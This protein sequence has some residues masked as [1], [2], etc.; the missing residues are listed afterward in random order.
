MDANVT[1]LRIVEFQKNG[2]EPMGIT[3]KL[4]EWGR[5]VVSRVL[6]GGLIDRQ[7]TLHVG[8]IITEINCIPISNQSVESLQKLLRDSR[9]NMFSF[10]IVPNSRNRAP[11]SQCESYFRAQFDYNPKEDDMIPSEEAGL[12]FNTGDILQVICKDDYYWWQSRKEGDKG[13]AGLIP[14]PELVEWRTTHDLKNKNNK[15]SEANC[16]FFSKSKRKDKNW[17]RNAFFD[18][19]NTPSYEEVVFMQTYPRK[20]L[21]LLGAHGIGRRN[22]KNTLIS[23]FPHRYSYPIPHTTRSPRKG[24]INKKHYFFVTQEEMMEEIVCNQFLEYGF[25]KEALYGIKIDTI[26][27]IIYNGLTPILDIEP[28]ALKILRTQEFAP[29]VVYIAAPNAINIEDRD[30]SLQRLTRESLLLQKLYKHYFDFTIIN[31]D[32]EETAILVE[33][34]FNLIQGS[35]QWVP[36]SWVY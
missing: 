34:A 33:K 7:G 36:C 2:S 4:D 35:G 31:N 22:I 26:R 20:T 32:I 9:G 28:Q 8:D 16:A 24:E 6:L 25:H 27:Q 21:V 15:K 3:L 17:K 23:H 30:G 5:C 10:K 12:V 1:P 13:S 18:L 11:S 14:S 29:F 19:F